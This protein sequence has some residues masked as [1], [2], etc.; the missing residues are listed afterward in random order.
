MK[1]KVGPTRFIE[2]PEKSG[3]KSFYS[4][5]KPAGD[6]QIRQA[7]SII[8]FYFLQYVNQTLLK[9]AQVSIIHGVSLLIRFICSQT[10]FFLTQLSNFS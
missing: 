2:Q 4:Y 5:R 6:M 10:S 8:G 9:T 3:Q 1:G 7:I